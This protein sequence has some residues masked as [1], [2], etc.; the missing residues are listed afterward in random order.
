MVGEEC[1]AVLA[2]VA[3]VIGN[4]QSNREGILIGIGRRNSL[5]RPRQQA[6]DRG[7]RKRAE[8]AV[9]R[10]CPSTSRERCEQLRERLQS[11]CV[12]KLVGE[13]GGAP[14]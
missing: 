9:D 1:F 14:G 4:A 7:Q 5:G 11:R 6:G 10:A 8:V 3:E 12:G 13:R 2:D